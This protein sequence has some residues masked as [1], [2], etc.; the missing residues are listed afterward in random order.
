MKLPYNWLK[1]F[2]ETKKTAEEVADKLTMAGLEVE[3]VVGSFQF[4]N[5]FVGEVVEI[6]KHPNADKLRIAKVNIGKEESLQIVCGASNLEKG[7]MVPVAVVGAKLDDFEIKKATLRGV[8]SFGMICSERELGISENHEGI[9]VLD[10]D[11]YP[12]TNLRDCLGGDK[13]IDVN[14][15]ANRPDCMGILGLSREVAVCIDETLKYKDPILKD[16]SNQKTEDLVEITVEDFSLCSRYMA[17]VVRNV[18]ISPSPDWL[19]ERLIACGVRPINNLIDVSNYVMLALG[20]PLHFFDLDKIKKNNGK[21]EIIVRKSKKNE[22][23]TTIDGEERKLTEEIL[24]IADTD[25][26]IAIAGIMG[27]NNSGIDE[28]TKNILI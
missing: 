16:N 18:S 4:D 9:M 27:G 21:A 17:R 20:Q 26:P 15:P 2:V 7:Q 28:N 22:K 23:I 11:L 24:L 3:E 6:E 19:K 12:G 14:I 13:V 25:K 10:S 8:D 5:V 1:E